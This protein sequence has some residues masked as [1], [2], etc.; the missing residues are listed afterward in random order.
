MVRTCIIFD[1]DGTLVDSETLCNQAFVDLVS[2]LGGPAELLVKRYRGEKLAHILSDI[3]KRIGKKLPATFEEHNLKP[4]PGV[5]D[6]L[7]KLDRPRC[8]A[9]SGPPHKIAQALKVSGLERY[10]GSNSYSS[11]VVGSWKPEPGLFLYAAQSMGF[12]PSDCIVVEDSN[13][14]IQAAKTA[15]MSA[16]RYAP[17]ST[18]KCDKKTIVFNKMSRLPDLIK[19]I[20]AS[21]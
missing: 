7:E 10:F 15:G 16:L 3:E 19:S 1:L 2:G 12:A 4:M 6:M 20:E 18:E 9:S 8:I 17:H 11:Y 5:V 13:F 21:F 14:G